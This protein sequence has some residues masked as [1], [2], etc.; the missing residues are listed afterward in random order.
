MKKLLMLL[1]C[2]GLLVACSQSAY[3]VK[4]SDSDKTLISGSEVKITK[5]DYFEKLLDQLGGQ[6]VVNEAINKIAEKELTDKDAYNKLLKETE[7]TYAKY[8]GGDLEKYAKNLG[9]KSKD[10]YIN[11]ELSLTVKKEL[12]I[13]KYIQ[14]NLESIIKDYQ[15]VSFKKITCAKESEALAIIKEA[16]S[17]EAFDKKLK[18][19]GSQGEDA[20]IVTKNS[21]LDQNLK[22]KLEKLSAINKD[23]VYNEAIKLSD[24]QYAVLYIYNTDHKN[25]DELVTKLKSDEKIQDD[26][27]GHYLKKY[28]F[29]VEDNKIKESVKKISGNYIE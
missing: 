19:A 2:G 28:N 21:T 15:I 1:L 16:T 14:E 22:T 3:N 8:S 13:K 6:E 20:G 18:A 23:G 5:Q 29:T 24:D 11:Q 25:T 4:V 9:Y 12:L 27:I 26:V 10:E 7:E 17:L